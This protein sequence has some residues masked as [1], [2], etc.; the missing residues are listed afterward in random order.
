VNDK[1]LERA[2]TIALRCLGILFLAVS[3]AMFLGALIDPAL[4]TVFFV[5]GVF[6]LAVGIGLLRAKG[7]SREEVEKYFRRK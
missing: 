4:R 2:F 5:A 3:P 7:T 1:I 6:S